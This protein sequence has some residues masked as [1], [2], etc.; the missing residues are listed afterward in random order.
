MV[1]D[2]TIFYTPFYKIRRENTLIKKRQRIQR[3][4]LADR[5]LP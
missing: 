1:I 2:P 3:N 4:S 5:D